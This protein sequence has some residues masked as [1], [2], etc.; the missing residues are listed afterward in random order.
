MDRLELAGNLRAAVVA[1]KMRNGLGY[2]EGKL[3]KTPLQ[4]YWLALADKIITE[5]NKSEARVIEEV[6]GE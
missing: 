2:T 1:A 4:S 6:V 3:S 5:D